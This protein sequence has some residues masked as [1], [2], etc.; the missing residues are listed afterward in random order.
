[1]KNDLDLDC[2]LILL[3]VGNFGGC[4]LA[5][6]S[7]LQPALTCGSRICQ[8]LFSSHYQH[9]ACGFDCSGIDV[10]SLW[11]AFGYDNLYC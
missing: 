11:S 7:D 3:Y 9:S 2:C 10:D 5:P 6:E 8:S 1:M 4:M